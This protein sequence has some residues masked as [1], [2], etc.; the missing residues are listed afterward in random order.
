VRHNALTTACSFGGVWLAG[1]VAGFYCFVSSELPALLAGM[2]APPAVPSLRV[3]LLPTKV[4]WNRP[5]LLTDRKLRREDSRPAHD[6]MAMT[7]W[8]L[9]GQR[10][11]ALRPPPTHSLGSNYLRTPA[12]R[13]REMHA[14][15]E[16]NE[17]PR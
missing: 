2:L 11:A 5:G 6:Q 10:S 7:R 16:K 15:D 14:V 1:W 13:R 9:R 17:Q 4:S 12:S 3:E 8:H